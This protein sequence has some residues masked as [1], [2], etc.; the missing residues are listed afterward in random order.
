LFSRAIAASAPG[1]LVVGLDISRAMLEVAARRA[2]GYGNIVLV[3]GADCYR[4]HDAC[5]ERRAHAG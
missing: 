2:K 1:A 5:G 4:L 3:R